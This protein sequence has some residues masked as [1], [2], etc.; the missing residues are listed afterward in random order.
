MM[1]AG[2]CPKCG[3]ELILPETPSQKLPMAAFNHLLLAAKL[4]RAH[5]GGEFQ[6]DILRTMQQA[7]AEA[8]QAKE[9]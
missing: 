4:A 1:I 2:E 3:A 9:R 5:I 8:E 7:I 6:K